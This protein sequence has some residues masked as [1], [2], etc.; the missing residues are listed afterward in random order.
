MAE[1]QTNSSP[2]PHHPRPQMCDISDIRRGVAECFLLQGRYT[3]QAGTLLL[4]ETNY[5]QCQA[6][7]VCFF[8]CLFVRFEPFPLYKD[9]S[10]PSLYDD[11]E[12]IL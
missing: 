11:D 9:R 7:L 3:T 4:T 6:V 10:H 1:L 5:R 8:L 12:P 2:P